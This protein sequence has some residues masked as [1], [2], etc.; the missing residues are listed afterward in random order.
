[1]VL[2]KNL[3]RLNQI[4]LIRLCSQTSNVNYAKTMPS[5]SHQREGLLIKLLE[6]YNFNEKQFRNVCKFVISNQIQLNDHDLIKIDNSIKF[7]KK[8]VV[9][10]PKIDRDT[11]E[12]IDHNYV[13]ALLEPSLLFIDCVEMKK[14]IDLV[15]KSGFVDGKGDISRLFLRAP[16]GE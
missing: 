4:K 8:F 14:R 6:S 13:L 1:M 2:F 11:D 12:V 15:Q 10:K 7:W 5:Y 3:I 9:E 16:R